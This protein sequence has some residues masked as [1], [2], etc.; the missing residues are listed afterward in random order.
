MYSFSFFSSSPEQKQ[1][2]FDAFLGCVTST[3]THECFIQ[4]QP[5]KEEE[6]KRQAKSNQTRARTK[7]IAWIDLLC[8]QAAAA[9]APRVLVMEQQ[10]R[11]LSNWT[12][13]CTKCKY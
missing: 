3:R 8:P 7:E 6:G 4:P 12:T 2:L 11:G 13:L 5:K 9:A 1:V 10:G